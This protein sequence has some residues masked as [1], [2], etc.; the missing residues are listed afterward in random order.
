MSVT[1]K[2]LKEI[3]L[4]REAGRLLELVH[5]ELAK[6]IR[7]GISTWDIDHLGEELIRSYGCVPNFL[8]YNGFPAS[9]CVSVN[10]EVVHG[11]PRKDRI[12]QEGDIVSLDA[13]LIYQGYHSDAAR[14]HAVGEISAEARKLVEVTRQSF[15]EG[16]KYAKAGHH[17]NEIS[18]AIGAYAESF[19]Y[20]VVTDLVGH[21]IGSSLH[22]DPQIP[23]FAQKRRGL[24]LQPGMT[25]AI[26]PM[27]NMGRADVC[28][29]DDDWTV[30]TEDGS[31]SAHYENTVLITEGEPELLTLAESNLV[32]ASR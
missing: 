32:N 9:I 24:R 26:E 30:V 13:G 1:I 11:I 6:A 8:N 27:I 4:M 21:G 16:I 19:G 14:T 5:D 20:G 10:D 18:A 25:L 15:F 29:L 28:W 31:W 7:P 3:E 17:L 2:S 12:L 23:N 22:E